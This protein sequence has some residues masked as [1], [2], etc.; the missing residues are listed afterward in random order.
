MALLPVALLVLTM[1]SI[2]ANA[3]AL[4]SLKV[5]DST[6]TEIDSAG[7]VAHV[8]VQLSAR[9]TRTVKVH[10]T[11]VDGTATAPADYTARSGTLRFR[12]GGGRTK[13]VSVPVAGDL[14]DEANE[15]F[16]VRINDPRHARI[17]DRVGV[18]TIVDDDPLPSIA[19]QDVAADEG[20]AGTLALRFPVRLSSRSG[21]Q[22]SVGYAIT[23]G[24][25]QLG[26]DYTVVPASGTLT[27][28][29]GSIV[30]YVTINVL[31]DTADEASETVNLTLTAPVNAVLADGSAVAT[32][33]NDD[34]AG[35]AVDN[36][37]IVDEGGTVTFTVSLTSA[38]PRPVS[39]RYQTVDGS[40]VAPGDYTPVSGMLAF[41]AGQTSRT[42][43]VPT[44]NDTV[45][46]ADE[47]FALQ[48][49]SP[50]D[51]WIADGTGLAHVDGNATLAKA[52]WLGSVRG[53]DGS[54][55][56]STTASSAP[57]YDV[58]W[59]RFNLAE[60]ELAT[61]DDLRALVHLVVFEGGGD[62]DL[63]VY[64]PDGTLIGRSDHSGTTAEDVAVVVGDTVA[65]D[66]TD[67]YVQVRQASGSNNNYT[68]R[69]EGDR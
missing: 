14:R 33:R 63:S 31:G 68:L 42:V 48:L 55:V 12:P 26:T 43:T 8:T 69:V 5:L 16:K 56:L 17:A 36:P 28:R 24:S 6:V 9:P 22:V 3:A 64:R 38:S 47:F 53:D 37:A 61:P 1:V 54:D 62:L 39:V 20:D 51:A 2:P 23:P 35:F 60:S 30:R 40:A 4:P 7:L 58:D 18:V 29:T 15:T 67:V 25:A 45:A 21:R 13:T 11:T 19:A 66:S 65:N 32:I 49:S 44:V 52:T 57:A 34:G 59:Y 27:F 50:V 46:E 41:A 10:Y